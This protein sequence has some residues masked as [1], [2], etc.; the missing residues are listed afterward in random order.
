MLDNAIIEAVT[1]VVQI[2]TPNPYRNGSGTI[3]EI[4]ESTS[5]YGCIIQSITVKAVSST[6]NG[7]VR[8]FLS[9]PSSGYYLQEE[10]FI[11]NAEPSSKFESFVSTLIFPN[12]GFFL[13]KGCKLG[14]STEFEQVFNIVAT[15]FKWTFNI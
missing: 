11:V 13:A 7:I 9:N 15:G 5:D 6:E 12:N 14:A 3:T 2:S 8:L 1:K 10:F 4:I